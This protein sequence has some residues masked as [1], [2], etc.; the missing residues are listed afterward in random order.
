MNDAAGTFA[1]IPGVYLTGKIHRAHDEKTYP[2]TPKINL[3]DGTDAL[4]TIP[5]EQ[6]LVVNTAKGFVVVTGCAH[7]GIKRPSPTLNDPI[8]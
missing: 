6:S 3:P 5:E 2:G 8:E 1:G 4:D 7:A